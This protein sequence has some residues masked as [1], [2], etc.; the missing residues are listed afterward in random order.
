MLSDPAVATALNALLD[1]AEGSLRAKLMDSW[2][3]ALN[4]PERY[5]MKAGMIGECFATIRGELTNAD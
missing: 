1:R 3:Q 4:D 2:L 5:R